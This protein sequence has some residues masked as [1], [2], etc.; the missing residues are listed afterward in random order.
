MVVSKSGCAQLLGGQGL[1]PW[2]MTCLWLIVLQTIW[3]KGNGNGEVTS[4]PQPP[5]PLPAAAV[6]PLPERSQRVLVPPRGSPQAKGSSSLLK[7]SGPLPSE[8]GNLPL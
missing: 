7:R 2:E 6:Q 1:R 3:W 5:P 8:A 4:I